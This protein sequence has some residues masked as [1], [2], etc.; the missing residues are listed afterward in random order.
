MQIETTPRDHAP[1]T[2]KPQA[3]TAPLQTR[4][5]YNHSGP[6]RRPAREV[7]LRDEDRIKRI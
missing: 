5:D 1:G 4:L 7:G 3:H 6:L 2:P